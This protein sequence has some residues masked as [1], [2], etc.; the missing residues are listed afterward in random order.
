MS[1]RRPAVSCI[2]NR[3]GAEDPTIGA[4][5]SRRRRTMAITLMVGHFRRVRLAPSLYVNGGLRSAQG[6]RAIGAYRLVQQSS[7]SNPSCRLHTFKDPDRGRRKDPGGSTYG[8]RHRFGGGG[9]GYSTYRAE[10]F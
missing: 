5:W 2:D 6:F 3:A 1:V 9:G 4:G 7:S 10:L 8:R